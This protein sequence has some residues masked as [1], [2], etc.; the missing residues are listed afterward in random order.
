P[1]G[2]Q[3]LLARG[4]S[5]RLLDRL[6]GDVPGDARLRRRRA[7]G[8]L[9]RDRRRDVGHRR[10]PDVPREGAAGLGARAGAG[11]DAA[12][13]F[14]TA[15][16]SAL[17]LQHALDDPA[18]DPHGATRGRADR[19]AAGRHPPAWGP[20]RPPRVGSAESGAG[21]HPPLSADRADATPGSSRRPLRDL[22]R[23]L[24]RRRA[25][26]D[27]A[28]AG[29]ERDRQ[30]RVR[31]PRTRLD[32]G[33]GLARGGHAAARG[34]RGGYGRGG[35]GGRPHR[36]LLRAQDEDA[37]R[38][39]VSRAPPRLDFGSAGERARGLAAA[40]APGPDCPRGGRLRAAAMPLRELPRPRASERWRAAGWVLAVWTL[41]GLFRAADRYF[42]DPFQ[43][44]RLEFG[45][46]EALAQNLLSSTIWA[47]LT[48]LV[49]WLARRSV[50]STSNWARPV[51]RL[52]A[53][54]L[55]FPGLHGPA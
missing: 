10:L 39:A 38:A 46:W 37:A 13:G 48:P 1:D 31:A 11:A 35:S 44:Q 24:R 30:R 16:A 51:G 33:P 49:V 41:V 55:V 19:R 45:L 18:P 4:G 28:P 26:P 8:D 47:A 25:E 17:P 2:D 50:P 23:R 42:S 7:S 36:R 43:L 9:L 20:Q 32:R 27:P 52:P 53:G 22:S 12:R 34:S 29:R 21:V 15:S 6:L 5:A 54:G 40:A 3:R 14:E